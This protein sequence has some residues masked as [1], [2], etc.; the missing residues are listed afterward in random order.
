M[1]FLFMS[2]FA[3]L[4]VAVDQ[5]V[6]FWTVANIDLYGHLDF[7]PG[8]LGLTY[9]QNT[10]AA[11]SA[12]EGARWLF[13]LVFVVLSAGIVYEYF[14]KRMPFSTLERWCIAAVYGG[15]LGNM[16]DRVRLGYV[17][18]MIQTEFMQFPVFN[19]ADCFITCGCVLLLG[20]LIFFNKNFWKEEKKS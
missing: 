18:D 16:I 5:A 15:G 13:V 14:F 1:Q 8:V 20:H 9:V 17:V 6:K 12:L 3:I 2:I 7:I 19:V 10:G 4:I 11:F